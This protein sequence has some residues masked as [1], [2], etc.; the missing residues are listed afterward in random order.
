[1]PKRILIT[2]S[3]GFIGSHITHALVETGYEIIA[4]KRAES[5]TW[6]CEIIND[7]ITWLDLEDNWQARVIELQPVLIIHSAWIGVQ[8]NDR[9]NLTSQ[10][11][12]IKFMVQLLE[13]CKSLKVEKFISFGSQAEYG[14]VSFSITEDAEVSPS[15]AYGSVK[16]ACQIILKTFC[17]KNN[18]EW[19]WLRLFSFFGE[20]EDD[21]WLIPSLIKRMQTSKEMDLTPGEQQYAYLYIGDF[22]DM[23][24]RI[25]EAPVKSGIYNISSEKV[26]HLKSLIQKI[27]DK[28]NPGFKLNFGALSY[29]EDQSMFVHGNITKLIKEI[30][31]IEFTD[32]DVA[33]NK[34]V[35]YYTNK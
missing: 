21:S 14:N 8:A 10:I 25:V 35:S 2:G 30:G 19:I 7:K 4:L 5:D 32:V 1:M 28:V 13:V 24:K 3:T 27:R 11:S 33:L 31:K 23:V 34:T 6:R 26:Y 18:I 15:T 22:A 29:R 20:K 9:N 16:L 17:E 12:N